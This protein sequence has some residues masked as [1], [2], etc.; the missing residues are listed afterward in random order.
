MISNC[1][2]YII[3]CLRAAFSGFS[4]LKS[5]CF[6]FLLKFFIKGSIKI[7]T[8]QFSDRSN[9]SVVYFKVKECL[10]FLDR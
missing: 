5:F 10:A 1:F 7:K 2:L 4:K 3:R 6:Y 8:I 9:C